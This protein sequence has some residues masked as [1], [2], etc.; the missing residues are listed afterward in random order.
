MGSIPACAGEPRRRSARRWR[1]PVYPRV[2]GGTGGAG[3][4]EAAHRGL[5]PRVRG[6]LPRCHPAS[7]STGSIPACAGEPISSASLIS[8]GKVYPRVCGGTQV[9]TP[10]AIPSWGLSPRVRGNPSNVRCNSSWSRSIPACAGEPSRPPRRTGPRA[11]YPRVCGGTLHV[12]A[13]VVQV[14]GLS[15]RV[16]GNRHCLVRGRGRARSIP[17]CA[18]EPRRIIAPDGPHQVYPRVCGGTCSQQ[19]PGKSPGGLS[20]RVRGNQPHGAP[21]AVADGSIPACAGEPAKRRVKNEVAAVYP[22]VC[23]GTRTVSSGAQEKQGLSPRVRG[24]RLVHELPVVLIRSIPACAGEPPLRKSG[25]PSRRV[26][27]RVCGGTHRFPLP[28]RPPFG[29]SPRVRG[30][31]SA[32]ACWSRWRAVY[33]R[34]CG[35]TSMGRRA[36]RRDWGLS[37]RVRGNHRRRP[38]CPQ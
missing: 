36:R 29:L 27:P 13:F 17:A 2:C 33:P 9:H 20:P 25:P 12:R 7:P 38:R 26:Y 14:G 3:D 8:G 32:A 31:P 23:G 22:R 6:N 1:H 21:G 19:R 30:N 4:S 5:S 24:N 18:G 10:P 35:G 28:R 11:V 37:P 34:V 15:P 16:R